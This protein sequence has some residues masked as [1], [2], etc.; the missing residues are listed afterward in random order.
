MKTTSVFERYITREGNRLYDGEQEFRFVGSNVPGVM[1]PYDFTLFLPDRM[2]LPTPWEQ[3]DAFKTLVQMNARVLRLWNL[4][5]RGPSEEAQPWHYVLGPGEFNEAAFK[6]LDNVMALANR[7][8]IRV[9]VNFA[10]EGGRYLGS[11]QTYAAHRDKAGDVFYSDPQLRED[12]KQTVKFVVERVNSITGIPYREDKSILAWQFGNEL[13]N[14]T[15]GWSGEMAAYIKGLDSNHLV[16]DALAYKPTPVIDPNIDIYS[17]HFYGDARK[18]DLV[19]R[20]KFELSHL[21]G[22]RP[23]IIGEYGPYVDGKVL[24][25]D[26]VVD[27]T[28]EMLDYVCSEQSVAGVLLWSLYFHHEKGGFKWHQIFTFP[29]T[30]SFHWPGFPSAEAQCEQALLETIRCAAFQI[31]GRA[32]PPVPVPEEPVLLPIDDVPLLTWRGSAGASGYDIERAP[33][34]EGPWAMIASNVSDADVAYRPLFSDETA[35]AGDTWYYRISARNVSGVSKA[36]NVVGPVKVRYACFVDEL[37]DFSRADAKSGNP[38]LTNDFNAFYAEYLFR[39]KG[40]IGDSLT[41]RVPGAIQSAKI[42]A[43][44]T[45]A[46]GADE[47][48]EFQ[49]SC[50][51]IH[52]EPIILNC[53]E[54]ILPSPPSEESQPSRFRCTMVEYGTSIPTVSTFFKVLWK[55]PAELDRVELQ[56]LGR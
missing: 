32:V 18:P 6:C 39:A 36:S 49:V 55:G 45:T 52:F 25:R 1:L 2:E 9:I 46:G 13:N 34:N 29:S 53:T 47:D 26:N 24:T 31:E 4:P 28:R 16:E 43:F 17:C 14:S 42:V 50:D 27:Q 40:D 30:W 35:V 37:Q 20:I 44:L 8:G 5:V 12:Y 54:H 22:E 51:G 15:P 21:H 23:L 41:Y 38:T 3:E 33:S 48:F 11:I 19:Q 56:H 7:Y 10:A